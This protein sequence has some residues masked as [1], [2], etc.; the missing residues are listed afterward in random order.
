MLWKTYS[1]NKFIKHKEGQENIQAIMNH[2][3]AELNASDRPSWRKVDAAIRSSA[4]LQILLAFS[5][6]P[7]VSGI[8]HLRKFI[9]RIVTRI[10]QLKQL[11]IS[12]EMPPTADT[13]RRKPPRRLHGALCPAHDG[14]QQQRRARQDAARSL[15]SA[16][17]GSGLQPGAR[18]YSAPPHTQRGPAPP[19]Q[20][21]PLRLPPAPR[22][23]PTA[24]A[25]PPSS[26][27]PPA[28]RPRRWLTSG[29]GRGKWRGGCQRAPREGNPRPWRRGEAK[30]REARRSAAPPAPLPPGARRPRPPAARVWRRPRPAPT[31]GLGRAPR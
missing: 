2:L 7:I 25:G 6:S 10:T 18:S 16:L 26:G 27:E 19:A 22:S 5:V 1:D 17:R 24:T 31:A 28:A 20:R 4:L 13:S 29:S 12:S 15:P 14:Q 3:R 23:L 8:P 21:A 11:G 9:V 30:R